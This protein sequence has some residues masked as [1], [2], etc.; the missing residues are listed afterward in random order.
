MD[1]GELIL[2]TWQVI[3][4]YVSTKDKQQAADHL[5]GSL[6][7]QGIDERELAVL[8]EDKYLKEC[9]EDQGIG[10]E[11]WEDEIDWED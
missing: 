6:L 4:R 10:S 9:L 3:S 2:H 11:E 5:V 8:L 7:D 1:E